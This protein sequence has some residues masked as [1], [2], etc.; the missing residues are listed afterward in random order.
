ATHLTTPSTAEAQHGGIY[1]VSETINSESVRA[2][3]DNSYIQN[4]R[5]YYD[6]DTES[7]LDSLVQNIQMTGG[8]HLGMVSEVEPDDQL[9]NFLIGGSQQTAQS[10]GSLSDTSDE[11]VEPYD[12]SATSY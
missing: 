1:V 4:G 11:D 10:G 5:G 9:F 12:F 7:F 8:S 2:N 3:L 6:D